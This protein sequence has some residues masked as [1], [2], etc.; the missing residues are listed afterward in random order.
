MAL[1]KGVIF[2]DNACGSH[3]KPS[4]LDPIGKPAMGGPS[5]VCGPE[6]LILSL[7]YKPFYV[8]SIKIR[9]TIKMEEK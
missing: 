1:M 6:L 4:F 8:K 7:L 9:K 5:S 2:T 3:T